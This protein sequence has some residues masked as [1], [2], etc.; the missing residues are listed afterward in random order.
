[1]KAIWTGLILIFSLTVSAQQFEL[2]ELASNPMA[3]HQDFILFD[4]DHDGDEDALIIPDYWAEKDILVC[5]NEK[6]KFS[7]CVTYTHYPARLGSLKLL[8]INGDDTPDYIYDNKLMLSQGDN[9]INAGI[10]SSYLDKK[11]HA[12]DIDGDGDIDL[13]PSIKPLST[14]EPIPYYENINNQEWQLRNHKV[15]TEKINSK[16]FDLEGDGDLDI[17][18]EGNESKE[19]W[20]N[21]NGIYQY[22]DNLS[23]YTNKIYVGPIDFNGDKKSDFYFQYIEIIENKIKYTNYI[24]FQNKEGFEERQILKDHLDFGHL[25]LFRLQSNNSIKNIRKLDSIY[26]YNIDENHIALDKS[27]PSAINS[28]DLQV[29]NQDQN[30]HIIY[31]NESTLFSINISDSNTSITQ[32]TEVLSD[33]DIKIK[34]GTASLSSFY[35]NT[36]N[37][38][39]RVNESIIHSKLDYDY[40]PFAHCRLNINNE[41]YWAVPE[42]S[43]TQP[44]HLY[45]HA[46]GKASQ[47]IDSGYYYYLVAD[48]NIDQ[49]E[50]D[51]L[52]IVKKEGVFILSNLDS[53]PQSTQISSIDIGSE[54]AIYPIY[55][56]PHQ[57]GIY[58]INTTSD[59]NYILDL[60]E[61]TIEELETDLLTYN[62]RDDFN[63]INND[64]V[65][66]FVSFMTGHNPQLRIS[67]SNSDGS[68]DILHYPLPEGAYQ[69]KFID[70]DN[71]NKY[72]IATTSYYPFQLN[73]YS[74]GSGE[75][76][77][78]NS[79]DLP[80][81]PYRKLYVSDF[82][83]DGDMDI[84]S[85]SPFGFY[86]FEN[87]LIHNS[88]E[89]ISESTLGLYP[90]PTGDNYISLF[91]Q[92][93]PNAKYR[94]YNIKGIMV[95]EGQM[96]SNKIYIGELSSGMYVLQTRDGLSQQN[97]KFIIQR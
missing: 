51:E 96:D 25:S 50:T 1:M 30:D 85:H 59:R 63:D 68:Y 8:H 13:L 77:L 60:S 49:D 16:V 43:R 11:A 93:E 62:G 53:E 80:N 18:F 10:S 55:N 95:Q 70:I 45:I 32:S 54:L 33:A 15:S 41:V 28:R 52:L 5:Y 76:N 75:L 83:N 90:N 14:N 81:I 91:G 48:V 17:I 92:L 42:L 82:G 35:I 89:S 21:N 58:T 7:D 87:E 67:T 2:H 84:L 20:I 37:E 56:S 4:Y 47:L 71:D 57:Y 19:I 6:L 86:L 79:I 27:I 61:G 97:Q 46:N 12:I 39:S 69:V 23:N 31:S 78:L 29:V 66:D 72:E 40:K 34:N 22:Y 26:I 38:F 3:R 88:T 65:L 24:L 64:G 36:L 9:Y 94:I 74:V 73:I 44:L